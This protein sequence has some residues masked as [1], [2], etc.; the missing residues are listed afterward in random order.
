[1]RSWRVVRVAKDGTLF[2]AEQPYWTKGGAQAA[3]THLNNT[4]GAIEQMSNALLGHNF[5]VAPV[6]KIPLLEQALETARK[7]K[8]K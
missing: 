6:H 2:V 8:T 4:F 5:F 1:M 3:A 7:E